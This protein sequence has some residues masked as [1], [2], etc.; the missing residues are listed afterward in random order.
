MNLYT[1]SDFLMC[2]GTVAIQ[3]ETVQMDFAFLDEDVRYSPKAG[4]IIGF[5]CLIM[6]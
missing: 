5:D 2:F 4:K 6:C 1:S 3:M